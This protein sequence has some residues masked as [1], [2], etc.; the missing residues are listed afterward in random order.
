MAKPY[1]HLTEGNRIIIAHEFSKNATVTEIAQTLQVHRTT[2]AREVRRNADDNGP[3]DAERAH[4]R[5]QQR[6]SS[7][8][9][10]SAPV[11]QIAAPTIF[12]RSKG[13]CSKMVFNQN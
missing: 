2:I 13:W 9:D 5:A 3:Y 12:L 6:R 7:Q 4:L 11:P 8:R 1:Q 10:G